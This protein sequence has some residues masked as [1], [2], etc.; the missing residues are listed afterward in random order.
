MEPDDLTGVLLRRRRSPARSREMHHATLAA[1]TLLDGETQQGLTWALL[2]SSLMHFYSGT[3][4]HFY[5][6]V[7]S[8]TGRTLQIRQDAV[9]RVSIPCP[10]A[11][12]RP[13][14]AA[15]LREAPTL[16]LTIAQHKLVHLGDFG[17]LPCVWVYADVFEAGPDWSG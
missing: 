10:V 8:W 4:T 6:G 11:L 9:V 14:L 2:Q 5:S 1:Q 17:Q 16:L 3:P 12:C 7:D 13:C 15:S